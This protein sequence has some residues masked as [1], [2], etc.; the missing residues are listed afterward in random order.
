MNR[1]HQSHRPET[2]EQKTQGVALVIVAMQYF[3]ALAAANI[4][5]LADHLPIPWTAIMHRHQRCLPALSFV[6]QLLKTRIARRMHVG[7][8]HP[9]TAGGKK[10]R[11]LE[12][13][14]VGTASRSTDD[15]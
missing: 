11:R 5:H 9:I 14:L 1:G 8:N 12:D 10:R 15:S 7:T 4:Q 13:R 6:T 3:D 2:F